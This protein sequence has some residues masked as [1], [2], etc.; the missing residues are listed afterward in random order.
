MAKNEIVKAISDR[1]GFTQKQIKEIVRLTFESIM[2]NLMTDGRVEF[3]RFG[4]FEV[5]KRMARTCKN[6]KTGSI[7][8]I[9]ERFVV[10]FKPS[11]EMEHRVNR[12]RGID[13]SGFAS[14]EEELTSR[15]VLEDGEVDPKDEE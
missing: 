15:E 1:T 13:W 8:Q 12:V 2:N 3:R 6:P 7:L 11:S 14:I 9:P 10:V 5:R 4:V